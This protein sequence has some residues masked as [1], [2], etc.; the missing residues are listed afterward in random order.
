MS[1]LSKKREINRLI[2]SFEKEADNF[3]DI[4]FHIITINQSNHLKD[5]K[6]RSPNH[7][8]TLWQYMGKLGSKVERDNFDENLKHS[9]LKW[10]I[11]G[12][13]LTNFGII[14]G[15]GTNLFVKMAKR[16]GS[17]FSESEKLSFK[18]RLLQEIQEEEL[19][20]DSKSLPTI[21]TND[22][23]LAVW[24][25]F[26]LYFI[27]KN[28]SYAELETKIEPDLFTLSL[29]ALEQMAE[30][31]TMT[32]S[33]KSSTKLS[34]IHFRVAVSFPGEKRRYVS[35]VV[36]CLRP[37]LGKDKVF[38]DFDYQA[39]IARPN[40]DILLQNI[41]HKQSELIV[42]FLCEEYVKKDWC[43]LEWRGI[44][45]LIKSK[46]D[47]KIMFIRFDNA[48]LDGTFSI[49]GYING[50]LYKPKQVADFILNRLSLQ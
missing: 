26:L 8:I 12:A 6:F 19:R 2:K 36:D 4:D 30:D 35:M 39:Q 33:D 17:L 48:K 11:R 21:V 7:A 20:K 15:T 46:D 9:D 50:N 29:L 38:Y 45:D 31:E 41:Y 44:R 32:K 10:G 24:L 5:E 16:A 25:N 34:E 22:N 37:I 3:H 49:D 18:S 23:P 14:E 47:E 43:G 1:L 13:E 27:S 42:I 40:A 28:N